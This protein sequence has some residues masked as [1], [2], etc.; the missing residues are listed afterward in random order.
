MNKINLIKQNLNEK[1]WTDRQDKIVPYLTEQRGNLKGVSS[2]LLKPRN[3]QDV[4]NIV[5]ICNEYKIPIVP[6]GGRTGLCGG[7]IPSK[8]GNEVILSTEL[9]NKII[10]IN[11]KNSI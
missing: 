5:K 10:N 11:R 3:T 2:L 9:M 4:V 8:Q 1:L 6:Q 7:T